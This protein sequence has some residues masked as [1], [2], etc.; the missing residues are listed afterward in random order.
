MSYPESRVYGY[1]RYK[2]GWV[3]YN[4]GDFKQSLA[5]FVDV[6]KLSQRAGKGS[7]KNALALEKEAKKDSVR[8]YARIGTPD[9]AWAF[10]KNIGGDYAMTM[11]ESL[12]ELYNGQG[13]FQDSIKVYRQLIAL[14]PKSPKV[15]NW[16]TEVMHNTLSYTGSKAHPDNVKELQRLAD[17][18]E[19]YKVN[20]TFKQ[21]DLDECKDNTANTLREL[22]TVWHKEAQK[23]N[24]MGTYDLA[25]YLYKE[26]IN[27]FPKEK[28]IYIMTFYY[29]E[30]LFKLGSMGENKQPYCDA[31]PIYS[32]VVHLD[33]SPKAKYLKEAAYAAVISW[34]NCLAVEDSAEEARAATEQKKKEK[35]AAKGKKPKEGEA[36]AT[37]EEVYVKKEI[38]DRQKKM[39]D[40]FDE[41][42]KYVPESNELC[43]IK[44]R[45]ARIYF[46]YN[47]I[48]EA[49]PLYKDVVDSCKTSELAVY[50]ANLYID[51]LVIKKD[52]K[53]IQD[54]V[55]AFL[56][57]PELTKDQGFVNRL[58]AIKVQLAGKVLEQLQR[59]KKYVE[60][61]RMGIKMAEENPQDPK[62]DVLYYD[63]GVNFEKAKLIG[64]AIQSREALIKLKPDSPLAKKAV[65]LV[66]RNYQD[67]AAFELAA[68]K[69]EDFAAKYPGELSK[70][71]GEPDAAL[72][73]NTAS[74]FRR[75]L[76]ENEKS[77]DDVKLFTKNYGGR[78]EFIDQAAGVNFYEYQIYEQKHDN[79][80]LVRHLTQYLKE[81]GTKGGV[82][83]QII[84]HA[85]LA[86]I[87]WK[88]SCPAPGGGV[89]G[90]CIELIRERA[91]GKARVEAKAASKKGGKKSKKK[92]S[93]LPK[94]CGPATKSRVIVHERTP[95]RSKEALTH[96]AEV[97]KLWKAGAATKNV[98]GKDE[99]E[100]GARINDMTYYAA[101]AR[102]V[103]ADQQYE[104][105]LKVN[106]PDKLDFTPPQPDMS[107]AKAKA[108]K[109][110]VEASTK[111]FKTYFENKTKLLG[112]TQKM[113][114]SVILFKNAH[115]AIASA[116]RIGQL[117]QDFSGQLYTAP[118]PK[119]PPG[120]DEAFF[121]DAY[122]DTL[123]DKAEPV[124]SHAIEGLSACLGKSTELS[125]FNE[126]STLCEAE[127][128]QIK[129]NEYPLAAEI[130]AQPGYSAV[131]GDRTPV[132]SLEVQ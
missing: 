114:Q 62:L 27:K 98:P 2:E 102:M 55:E 35:A 48:E 108:Q 122:C 126:W 38:P 23:T 5:T 127:L 1:A 110:K 97:M 111:A 8:A 94:Q 14:E 74:F 89:N 12:G 75:G 41:Y 49:T 80:G 19:G 129:P 30:L 76:G 64:A 73:L 115:W 78:H 118:V 85:K 84:A 121:H 95:A 125:W 60:A 100:R 69:Y 88:A 61:A 93:D 32:K 15:C 50:S 71:P 123:V 4:M 58:K 63:A 10:F 3:Y 17:V 25:Q 51:C 6:I 132:Q 105:F 106:I 7:R 43:T 52:Y 16:Q 46:D 39:I 33:P 128:N 101:E 87:A 83:R 117:F 112:D 47:H 37:P 99:N 11:L 79:D 107:P 124:E 13:Q 59:D 120:I 28:D 131:T 56:T 116:A 42:I 72:A 57:R 77:F 70:K 54:N 119:A 104:K 96:F 29:G 82:D 31:A 36:E 81:W 20:K 53:G 91:G 40:A 92:G 86:E 130:R 24:D 66:G 21:S 45:K 67:I 22:A 113:Y 18:Y 26:Y 109:A 103:E 34:K 90:A 9:K 44:Y 68:T 65:Y